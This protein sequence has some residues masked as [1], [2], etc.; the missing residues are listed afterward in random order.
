MLR[1][2][3][4]FG[5]L[6]GGSDD[7]LHCLPRMLWFGVEPLYVPVPGNSQYLA[8]IMGLST[9]FISCTAVMC[10]YIHGAL[11]FSIRRL[12]CR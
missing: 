4:E 11:K 3:E 6:Y 12:L 8:Y 10:T 2:N 9:N 5:W 7:R 1:C